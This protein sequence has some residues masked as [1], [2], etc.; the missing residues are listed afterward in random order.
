MYLESYRKTEKNLEKM[1]I[2]YGSN[3]KSNSVI[4]SDMYP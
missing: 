2:M 4:F 3:T 1:T